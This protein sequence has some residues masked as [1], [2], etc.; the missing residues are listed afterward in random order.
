MQYLCENQPL[1]IFNILFKLWNNVLREKVFDFKVLVFHAYTS[2]VDHIPLGYSSDAMLCNY[3]CNS[4][5]NA[6]KDSQNKGEVN[7]F[8][9]GLQ[10]VVRKILTQTPNNVENIQRLTLS[11]VIS[12]LNIKIERGFTECEALL[13]Y[14]TTDLKQY[15]TESVDIVDYINLISDDVNITSNSSKLQFLN[16][17]KT[18]LL[19]LSN[20]RYL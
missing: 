9:E 12:I 19:S 10:L 8:A 4:I 3:L 15:Y 20:A 1:V 14:L 18:Y 6:I 11:K 7:I 2:F 5:A 16:E 13:K 17:L